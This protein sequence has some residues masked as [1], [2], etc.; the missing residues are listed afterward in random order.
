MESL[1]GRYSSY[2]ISVANFVCLFDTKELLESFHDRFWPLVKTNN[3]IPWK[4]GEDIS[5]ILHGF[6]VVSYSGD[7][8][9]IGKIVRNMTL[10]SIQKYD[11]QSEKITSRTRKLADAPSSFVLLRLFDHRL[12]LLR[13]MT[14][15]PDLKKVEMVIYKA[16]QMSRAK[17]KKNEEGK[18]KTKH[19]RKNLSKELR[20]KFED[21]FDKKFP[22]AHFRITPIASFD[23]A[24]RVLAKADVFK[25]LTV[26]LHH[27]NQEDPKFRHKLL[28]QLKTARSTIGGG[29]TASAKAV[30][31]D[32][33]LGLNKGEIKSIASDVAKSQGNASL[34][35]VGEGKDGERI[36]IKDN[37]MSIKDKIPAGEAMTEEAKV[38]SAV[39]KL[40]THSIKGS[41]FKESDIRK[42]RN[43]AKRIYEQYSKT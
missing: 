22:K 15:S 23:L 30:I 29:K 39:K 1:M 5:Y 6:K 41:S 42:Y 20:A 2:P 3:V 21:E 24:E 10:E 8:Y 35:V 14:R 16:L 19:R 40:E 34:A 9:L 12:I 25:K 31:V 4:R 11:D 33:E 32:S 36:E 17:L 27:T 37:E 28:Q 43:L 38:V 18:F 26:T 7:Y 13:E